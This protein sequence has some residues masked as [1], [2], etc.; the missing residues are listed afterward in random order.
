ME[1]LVVEKRR[2]TV[3]IWLWAAMLATW[4]AGKKGKL[5]DLTPVRHSDYEDLLMVWGRTMEGLGIYCYFTTATQFAWIVSGR[6]L[7]R[8]INENCV[9]CCFLSKQLEGQMSVLAKELVVPCPVFIHVEVDQVGPLTVKR[10]P[11]YGHQEEHW[12]YEGLGI[13][14]PV[15]Q[16]KGALKVL[17]T[18]SY[19][20]GDFCLLW[21]SLWLR[22]ASHSWFTVTGGAILSLLAASSRRSRRALSLTGR[23]WMRPLEARLSGDSVPPGRQFQNGA[24]EILVAKCK[25]T[26]AKVA[27]VGEVG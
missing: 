5:R 13:F 17:M 18:R 4:L 12:D 1:N 14:V 6:A 19:S 23:Q 21:M 3:L 25:R 24:T 9:R 20:S 11:G 10:D 16:H 8:K 22:Q 27:L 2:K 15:S 26:L 7:A